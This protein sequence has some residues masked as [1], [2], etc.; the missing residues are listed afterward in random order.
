MLKNISIRLVNLL[1][2]IAVVG[3]LA[4]ASYL[5]HVKGLEPC[6]LCMVQRLAFMGLAAL[7]F[8]GIFL[9]TKPTVTKIHNGLI[10]LIAGLGLAAAF[11]QLWLIHFSTAI[12]SCGA[13]FYYM[14]QHLPLGEL[15]SQIAYGHGDC[16]RDAWKILG[17]G[18]PAWSAVGLFFFVGVG[19][20]QMFR[21]I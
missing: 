10:I 1:L 12:A 4:L 15:F 3:L 20:W 2:L 5:Q 16:T 21:K 18:L 14:V 7:F 13:D 17:I 19:V 8:I 6:P 11:R 9:P